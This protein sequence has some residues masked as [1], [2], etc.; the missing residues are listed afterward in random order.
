LVS[1]AQAEVAITFLFDQRLGASPELKRQTEAKLRELFSGTDKPRK[2]DDSK[3]VAFTPASAISGGLAAAWVRIGLP[4][5]SEA[6][7]KRGPQNWS[8]AVSSWEHWQALQRHRM[9]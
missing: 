5:V 9:S 3:V 1:A 2:T 6:L 7:R 4:K 8:F